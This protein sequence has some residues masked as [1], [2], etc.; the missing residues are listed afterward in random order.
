MAKINTKDLILDISVNLS[1]VGRF[2]LEE[3]YDRVA[4]F[5]KATKDQLESL[6]QIALPGQL[7]FPISQSQK[8]VDQ[9]SAVKLSSIKSINIP[10]IDDCFT[11]SILLQHRSTKIA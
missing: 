11:Y 2:L 9:L 8:L 10:L 3:K 4:Q 6:S 1:R 5:T 7:H